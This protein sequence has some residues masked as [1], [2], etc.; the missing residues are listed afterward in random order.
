LEIIERE[1]SEIIPYEKNPRVNNNAVD[2]TMMSI[3]EY[4]FQQPIVVDKSGIVIAGH[5]RV[6]AAIKLGLKTCPVIV[7]ENLSPA[8]TKAFRLADNKTGELAT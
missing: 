7:A 4:G 1:T 6:K 5:T 2:K 8:Q 3:K